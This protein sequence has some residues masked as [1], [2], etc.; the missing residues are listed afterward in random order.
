MA[1]SRLSARKK[2]SEEPEILAENEDFPTE[3]ESFELEEPIATRQHR[4]VTTYVEHLPIN[5][6]TSAAAPAQSEASPA[7]AQPMADEETLPPHIAQFLEEMGASPDRYQL[8]VFRLPEFIKNG[9]TD[10]GSRDLCGI[11]DFTLDYQLEVQQRWARPDTPN[12]FIAVLKQNGKYVKGGT[13]PKF[14]CEPALPMVLSV[15]PNAQMPAYT[16][17]PEPPPSPPQPPFDPLKQMRAQ[18]EMMKLLRETF[19]PQQPAAAAADPALDAETTFLKVLANDTDIVGKLAKGTL[20]KLL[21]DSVSSDRDPW[22]EVA[23]EAIK[24][25][26]GAQIISSAIT[27]LFNGFNGMRPA[28]PAQ[29]ITNPTTVEISPPIAPPVEPPAADQS[30]EMQVLSL[31]LDHCA[32]QIPPQIAAQRILAIADQLNDQA[33]AFSIDGYLDLFAGLEPMAALEMAKTLVPTSAEV[34]AHPHAVE[35]TRELQSLLKMSEEAEGNE[36]S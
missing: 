10:P 26:Q 23:L 20:G 7:P 33:P 4:V 28:A 32:R 17:A 5:E 11:V 19:G 15:A 16:Y 2:N 9:R 6:L 29:T 36:S 31:A 1:K 22:A 34:A 21:G 25:G 8:V 12:H 30:P 14:S 24:S 35:W 18:L 27:A 3:E 13:L